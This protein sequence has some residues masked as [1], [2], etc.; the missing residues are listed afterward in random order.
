MFSL[1]SIAALAAIEVSMQKGFSA[2][3]ARACQI[4]LLG[5]P[6][7]PPFQTV[8]NEGER[9]FQLIVALD[10]ALSGVKPLSKTEEM[11]QWTWELLESMDP[12]RKR[13]EDAWNRL[14]DEGVDWTE[15]FRQYN[16]WHDQ[17]VETSDHA[18]WTDRIKDIGALEEQAAMQ[19]QQ[20]ID[21]VLS[22]EPSHIKHMSPQTKVQCATRLLAGPGLGGGVN[23]NCVIFEQQRQVYLD[24][25]NVAF[26][27]AG[28]RHDH[29]KYPN[30]LAQLCP[31]YIDE[32][33][34]DAFSGDDLHYRRNGDGYLLYSVGPN[35][36]DDGG[37]NFIRDHEDWSEYESATE[38]E[39]AADDIA[40]RTPAKR[41]GKK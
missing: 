11:D 14:L 12:D 34:L 16:S 37:H 33:P 24:L 8:M 15:V 36:R 31:E 10:M 19:V 4:D 6:A 9:L 41:D 18:A 7:M 3:M 21:L 30:R 29:G 32:V 35:M 27:L 17:I 38:E 23:Q 13:R 1:E 20:A 25:A 5:L 26:A 28:Y 39:K 2:A 40:I 22:T